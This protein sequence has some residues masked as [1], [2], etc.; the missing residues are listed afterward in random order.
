MNNKNVCISQWDHM[1]LEDNIT[2][3]MFALSSNGN[4]KKNCNGNKKEMQGEA[5]AVIIIIDEWEII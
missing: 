3:Q 2:R 5:A 4:N 1:L